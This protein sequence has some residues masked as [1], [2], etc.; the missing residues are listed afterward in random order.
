MTED[1]EAMTKGKVVLVNVFDN[2]RP[3]NVWETSFGCGVVEE[4]KSEVIV[5]KR[6]T[7]QGFARAVRNVG[8]EEVEVFSARGGVRDVVIPG[9]LAVLG[10][11]R[12]HVGRGVVNVVIIVRTRGVERTRDRRRGS[13]NDLEVKDIKDAVDFLERRE[14]ARFFLDSCA[15]VSKNFTKGASEVKDAIRTGASCASDGRDSSV[16]VAIEEIVVPV[17][18]RPAP[19]VADVVA[20]FGVF[21]NVSNLLGRKWGGVGEEG[22]VEL[23]LSKMYRLDLTGFF[24]G[25]RGKVTEAG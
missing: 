11:R 14:K 13:R 25:V 5:D 6:S 3:S 23:G 17:F 18:L 20:H 7:E 9:G 8:V 24:G 4:A 15:V 22:F 19:D 21:E 1:E 2:S 12:G 10:S 16:P